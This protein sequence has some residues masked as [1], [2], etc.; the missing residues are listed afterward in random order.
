MIIRQAKTEDA[1]LIF[2]IAEAAFVP[3]PWPMA[4]FEHELSSPRSR[5]FIAN[6]GFIGVTQ[7]FDEIEIGSL[8]VHPDYQRRG[9]AQQLLNQVLKQPKV[10]RFLL[11]VD[12][13]NISAIQL[14]EKNGFQAY[15]RREKYYKNGHAAIMMER[16]I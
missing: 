4:V 1:R 6:A 11:E 12:E 15:F 9:I 2:N 5:Y 14:Y 10:K 3:S 16:N 7:I 8:A 13:T